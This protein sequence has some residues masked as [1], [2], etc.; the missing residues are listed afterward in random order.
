M[1]TCDLGEG[2]RVVVGAPQPPV[3]TWFI[4]PWRHRSSPLA[5]QAGR[6]SDRLICHQHCP[7]VNP[8]LF[9]PQPGISPELL[10]EGATEPVAEGV[11]FY[12]K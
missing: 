12:V 10:E 8:H 6:L 2:D 1:K 9:K 5:K 4:G 11:T 3:S 7:P